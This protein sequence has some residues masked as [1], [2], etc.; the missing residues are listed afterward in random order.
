MPSGNQTDADNRN[1]LTYG[2]DEKDYDALARDDEIDGAGD[3]SW[4]WQCH[5][6]RSPSERGSAAR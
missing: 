1:V 2:D 3:R 4:G 6:G 5:A